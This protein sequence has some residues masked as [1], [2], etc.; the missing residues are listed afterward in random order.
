MGLFWYTAILIRC[1][2]ITCSHCSYVLRDILQGEEILYDY[3]IEESEMP[4]KEK[5]SLLTFWLLPDAMI[6][7]LVFLSQISLLDV[8]LIH[9]IRTITIP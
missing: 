9:A 7:V 1:I 8:L 2:V 4:W 6:S 3:G 5:V